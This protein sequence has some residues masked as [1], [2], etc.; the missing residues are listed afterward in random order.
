M[1]TALVS[2]GLG[3]AFDEYS[4]DY[5]EIEAISKAAGIGIWQV[6]T[7]T[8]WSFR[9]D[10]WELAAEISPSGRCP[11]KGNIAAGAEGE[12]IYHTSWSPNY[13]NTKIDTAEGER[14]FCDE[15]EALSAG[16]RAVPRR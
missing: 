15:N 7:Q 9:A 4:G 14:R 5:T 16:W 6:D 1:G 8:P 3:C 13:T 2:E 12:K 11:I 10:T